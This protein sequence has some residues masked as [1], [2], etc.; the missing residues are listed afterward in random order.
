MSNIIVWNPGVHAGEGG[1]AVQSAALPN[2]EMDIGATLL[3]QAVALNALSSAP[4]AQRLAKL[5]LTFM[6]MMTA[7]RDIH[8]PAQQGL[9]A[10]FLSAFSEEPS[11]SPSTSSSRMSHEQVSAS[12]TNHHL[13]IVSSEHFC[14]EITTCVMLVKQ[15]LELLSG[16]FKY[17]EGLSEGSGGDFDREL[18]V[19]QVLH[20]LVSLSSRL[21]GEAPD[22]EGAPPLSTPRIHA[23]HA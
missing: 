16:T 19:V 15:V 9:L 3:D 13:V 20:N 21:G 17:T 23:G 6:Q 1:D 14:R 8:L 4:A 10:A 12:V 11:S 22:L 18:L 7:C 5:T 2:C